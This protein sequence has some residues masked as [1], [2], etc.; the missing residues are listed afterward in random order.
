MLSRLNRGGPRPE[1]RSRPA[2]SD[3]EQSIVENLRRL[4]QIRQGNSQSAPRCG[5]PDF[6]GVFQLNSDPTKSLC[7]S[8]RAMV[9][10]FEPRLSRVKVARLDEEFPGQ[11]RF[12]IRAT[13]NF[14]D[15]DVAFRAETVMTSLD[16]L[17]VER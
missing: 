8:I 10:E 12:E 1:I 3:I 5:V 16:R 15:R 14:D 17:T 11:L 6:A 2:L 13:V 4:F 7:D 9:D